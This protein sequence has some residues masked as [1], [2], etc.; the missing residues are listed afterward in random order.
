MKIRHGFVSNSSSSSFIVV[1]PS[2]PKNVEDLQKMMFGDLVEIQSIYDNDIFY[3]ANEIAKTVWNDM[4]TGNKPTR[5]HAREV[6]MCGTMDLEDSPSYNSY[7]NFEEYLKASE[8]FAKNK[9]KK[10]MRKNEI[11][12]IFKYSDNDGDYSSFLEH[13][14]IFDN[15]KHLRISHH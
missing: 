12:Y 2:E 8:I 14:G 9:F 7:K 15:L 3:S 13:N 1:F 6:S 4:K 5:K 11:F 10:F